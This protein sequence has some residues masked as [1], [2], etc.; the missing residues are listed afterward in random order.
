MCAHD[1][2]TAAKE[3]CVRIIMTCVVCTKSQVSLVHSLSTCLIL[4]CTC[5][6]HD[7]AVCDICAHLNDA[8]CQVCMATAVS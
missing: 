3:M 6:T 5:V 2:A 4:M 8:R 1:N 7:V